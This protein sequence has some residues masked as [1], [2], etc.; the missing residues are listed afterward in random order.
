M[1]FPSEFR[2][3]GNAKAKRPWEDYLKVK[4]NS[5]SKNSRCDLAD[6]F[7]RLRKSRRLSQKEMADLLSTKQSMVSR[8]EN[9]YDH[10]PLDILTK[11]AKRLGVKIIISSES[12]SLIKN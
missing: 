10:I 4:G 2:N 8:I 3:A 5:I 6:Q 11:I 12:V 9:G 1:N 7:V